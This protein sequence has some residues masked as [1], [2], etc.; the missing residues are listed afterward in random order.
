MICKLKLKQISGHFCGGHA[1]A[2]FAFPRHL[3]YFSSGKKTTRAGLWKKRTY[4]RNHWATERNISFPI[5]FFLV[6]CL[7]RGLFA[8]STNVSI[9]GGAESGLFCFCGAGTGNSIAGNVKWPLMTSTVWVTWHIPP[10]R[11]RYVDRSE[12]SNL[13]I[14]CYIWAGIFHYYLNGCSPKT[15]YIYFFFFKSKQW[16]NFFVDQIYGLFWSNHNFSIRI[17]Y[18]ITFCL[19]NKLF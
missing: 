4:R 6:N 5:N 9:S 8:I 18:T 3:V 11:I 12:F 19:L 1:P 7:R 13:I 16:I 10:L 14:W 17:S 2:V 15:L